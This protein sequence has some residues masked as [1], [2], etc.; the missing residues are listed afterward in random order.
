MT[1][2]IAVFWPPPPDETTTERYQEIADAGIDLVITGNYL[3]DRT[4]LKHALTRADQTGLGMLVASDPRIDV[5]M[6]DLDLPAEQTRELIGKV[7][8]DYSGHRSF[9]GI[10][11]MDEPYPERYERL[12]IG[13]AAVRDRGKLAYVNLFPSHATGEYDEY[14]G[15]FVDTVKPE[16]VSFD[17]YPFLAD[18][19]YDEGYFG[20]LAVI[21]EHAERAGVPA[22][23]YIQTLAYEGHRT[24][25]AAE[26]AWQVNTALAYGYT[27]IQYFT[28]WTPDPSRGESFQPALVHDG[29]RTER[30]EVVKQLNNG[31]LRPVGDELDALTWRSVRH[32]D[33]AVI[34]EYGD[35]HLLVCN[36][37]FDAPSEVTVDGPV[38]AFDPA[39]GSYEKSAATFTLE[40]GAA[41]LLMIH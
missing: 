26:I 11:L 24:P 10:S 39:S 3:S 27:G 2:T 7:I 4:I 36:A 22:W 17:R 34:G 31:W 14:V 9:R 12:A 30:Y 1:F 19:A 33:T 41:R 6:K 40:P 21:R 5:V 35:R 8:D 16:L 13:V 20:D 25:N 38:S 29:V 18:G 23:L 28:Y 15:G 37:R 32:T